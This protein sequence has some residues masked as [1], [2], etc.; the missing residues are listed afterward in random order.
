MSNNIGVVN[1]Y[2][3][4]SVPE[5]TEVNE[6]SS[7]LGVKF[8]LIEYAIGALDNRIHFFTLDNIDN[9]KGKNEIYHSMFLHSSEIL[10][11]V[12]NNNGKVKRYAGCVGAHEIV[13]DIDCKNDLDESQKIAQGIVR[14]IESNYEVELN[15]IRVNF[16]G[17]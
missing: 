7:S 1:K 2:V 13:I 9:Y 6:N 5:E 11:Y 14:K 8:N 17:Y 12:K 10:E 15:S 4:P 3:T 16:S